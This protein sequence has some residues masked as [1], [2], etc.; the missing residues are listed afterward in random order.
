MKVVTTMKVLEVNN[1]DLLGKRFNGYDLK[2]YINNNT[3]N[4]AKQIV[5]IKMSK[6]KNVISFFKNKE[7]LSK[8]WKLI[9]AEKSILSVHSILSFT[10][11]L[12]IKSKSFKRADVIHYHLIHNTH[13]SLADFDT[14]CNQKPAVLS[15]HDPWNFTGRCVHPESCNK[16]KTG[17]NNCPKLDTLFPMKEDNCN[18]LWKLKKKIYKN[19]DPDIIVSTPYMKEFLKKSPLTKHFKHVHV[20]PFG[21]ELDKF[22]IKKEQSL[23]K[24]HFN[25][26]TGN[27][28]L[29]LRAQK[30]FKGTEY[31]LRALKQLKTNKR[32]S[33][34]TCSEKGLLDEIKNKY[35]VIDLGDIKDDVMIEA[36]N[37]CDIFLMPSIGESFGL[38]AVEA[39]ASSKPVIVF[40]NTALPYVTFAPECGMLVDNKNSEK[41][42]EAIKIL[43]ENENERKARGELGR[44]LAEENYSIEKYNKRILNIYEKAYKRF[45][46][47][48]SKI[49]IVNNCN[50][51]MTQELLIKLKMVYKDVFPGFKYPTSLSR[52]M[53]KKYK[54][55]NIKID[56]SKR[57]IRDIIIRF[58]NEIYKTLLVYNLLYPLASIKH[59]LVRLYYFIKHNVEVFN[60]FLRKIPILSSILRKIKHLCIKII[61]GGR[62]E[63]TKS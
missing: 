34:L 52:L 8:E 9:E 14:L 15:I 47:N 58:N 21:I 6:D 4:T 22:N 5:T 56:Y 17:C 54:A 25:I 20:V 27:I 2:E 19:I 49:N 16:W 26:P 55:K 48:R 61:S 59:I 23:S 11:N 1:I 37:A 39:M 46:Q 57:E 44:K 18:F 45:K 42:M 36:Y 7:V 3:D 43:V 24:R 30:E 12:L 62:N 29:F 41:L 63:K 53:E 35:Q 38:M 10:S 32:I 60:T 28:V 31:V 50:S 51:Q 13:L 33:I 40:N